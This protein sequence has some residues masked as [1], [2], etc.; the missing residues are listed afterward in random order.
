[1]VALDTLRQ[2]LDAREELQRQYEERRAELDGEPSA[3]ERL[4]REYQAA[5]AARDMAGWTE[6]QIQLG[7]DPLPHLVQAWKREG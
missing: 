6:V 7:M 4:D 1:M 2:W 3:L 5:A